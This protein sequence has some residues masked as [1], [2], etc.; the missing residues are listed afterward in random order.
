MTRLERAL[1]LRPCFCLYLELTAAVECEVITP[2]LNRAASREATPRGCQDEA[3]A[4]AHAQSVEA[5]PDGRKGWPVCRV[6]GRGALAR[7][8]VRAGPE[9]SGAT[10][11]SWVF[12]PST[13]NSRVGQPDAARRVSPAHL[14]RVP[15]ASRQ[16]QERARAPNAAAAAGSSVRPVRAEPSRPHRLLLRFNTAG[17]AHTR[18]RRWL[19]RRRRHRRR[20]RRRHH[21][22]R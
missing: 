1:F 21:H 7:L 13:G 5:P 14:F 8:S 11:Q 4:H 15:S 22:R 2:P 12:V 3:S 16:A 18:Q 20:R 10:R 9:A 19:R 17:M 6:C